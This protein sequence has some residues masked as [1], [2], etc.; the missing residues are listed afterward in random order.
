MSEP[1]TLT[2]QSP[3]VVTLTITMDAQQNVSVTGP[4]QNRLLAYGLLE[5]ARDVILEYAQQ[6]QR[7]VQPA[8]VDEMAK[9]SG[10]MA[11]ARKS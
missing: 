2:E 9:L 5:T 1:T 8:G 11:A 10:L 7:K 4:I 6:Q 3:V